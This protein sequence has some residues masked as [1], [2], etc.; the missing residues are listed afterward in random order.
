MSDETKK[1]LTGAEAIAWNLADLYTGADDP[2]IDADLNEAFA[3]AE[4]MVEQYKGRIARLSADKLFKLVEGLEAIYELASKPAN[5]ASLY[6][7]IN[8][9]DPERGALVQKVR[10]RV[11]RLR[12]MLV[13]IELEWANLSDEKA[14]SLIE[15][16]VLA[17]YRH[18]LE[19]E[20]L[21]RPYLLSE[22]EE[23][24]LTEKAVTGRNAWARYFN[25][26]HAAARYDWEGDQVSLEVLLNKLHEADREVR[27]RAH[28]SVTEGLADMQH[29]TTF[30]FNTL[31]A[32]KASDDRLRGYPTWISSRNLANEVD[33]DA[34]Q[35]L[36]DSVTS[37]YDIVARYYNLKKKLLGVDELFDYDRYAPLPA[38]DRRYTWEEARQI[39]L[40]AYDKFHPRMA[41]IAGYFFEKR[42]IDAPVRPGK[43]HGAYS[44]RTVP[45][46]H[47]YVFMN[48]QAKIGD[49]M[50]LAHELGH[51]V[52]Q[53][54]SNK[55]GMLQASTPLTTAE[56]ASTFG[57]ML[58]F[59]KLLDEQDDPAVRLAM[60][61]NKIEDSFATIFRQIAMNRFEDTIHTA[62]REQ[63]E[64]RTEQFGEF[65]LQTQRDMFI[66]SVTMTTEYGLWWSYIPHFVGTPGY[67]YAYSF[68]ELLV[69]ALY[70]RY[71][72]AGA[73]FADKYLD[74]LAM[75]GSDWP[76]EIVKPLGVDLEDPDF[77]HLGLGEL[78]KMVDEAERLAGQV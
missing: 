71:L 31:L 51:G 24:L 45:S 7:T 54:L 30:I 12:Q 37:R 41:E 52:H 25:E 64:L 69:M 10:E 13:F 16:P 43:Q 78:E 21:Y 5:F 36:I 62:R 70:A 2:A 17:R 48:Y 61:T 6:W 14:E 9:E 32:D 18:W 58:V 63:G 27:V 26:V 74:M 23:K 49:V 38:A 11:A 76:H 34:V 22:P 67:V 8:T 20:R 56:T 39:V 4:R 15:D 77:W 42:W 53:Y 29:T 68:G 35:V 46:V 73:G 59:H 75:G 57:E 33:D 19:T 50:T 1:Q 66:D 40:E 72:E 55:Q 65:W 60:Y 28:A 47:P 44:A 3:R